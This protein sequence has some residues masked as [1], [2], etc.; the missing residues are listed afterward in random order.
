MVPVDRSAT[1]ADWTLTYYLRTNTS[2]EGHTVAGTA[3]ST[4]WEFTISATDSAAFDAGAWTFEALLTKS[5]ETFRAGTGS[6]TIIQSQTYTGT[7]AA[8]DDRTTAETRLEAMEEAFHALQVG[9][10]GAYSIGSRSFTYHDLDKMRLYI[11]D[12]RAQ[13]GREKVRQKI[14]NGLGNPRN[15][16]IRF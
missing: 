11:I 13:V 16:A 1:S 14:A 12:L 9:K 2:G 10:V 7:P 5:S 15:F 3:Y 8:L 4:G 6:I